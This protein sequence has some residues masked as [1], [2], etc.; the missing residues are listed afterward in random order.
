[1][2]VAN[3]RQAVNVRLTGGGPSAAL[4]TVPVDLGDVILHTVRVRIPNGHNGSTRLQVQFNG[5]PI[6]PW[7][8]PSGSLATTEWIVGNDETLAFTVEIEVNG[9]LD[10]VARNLDQWQHTFYLLFDYTPVALAGIA[11]APTPALAIAPA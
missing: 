7:Q 5:V 4:V 1:M 8:L 6:V 11:P 9:Q 2:T 10:I 3:R